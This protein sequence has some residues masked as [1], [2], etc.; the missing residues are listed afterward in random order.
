MAV[1]ETKVDDIKDSIEEIKN[2]VKALNTKIDCL[3]DKYAP[4]YLVTIVWGLV[5]AVLGAIITLGVQRV[6]G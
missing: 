1:I 2:S 5:L 3:D 4:K 6:F